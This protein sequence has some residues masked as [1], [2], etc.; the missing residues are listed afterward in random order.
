MGPYATIGAADVSFNR[1]GTLLYAAVV[2]V[3]ASDF[4]VLDQAA[5]EHPAA[6]P[7]VPGLLSFREAP[8]VLAAFE[9]LRVRPEVLLCDGQGIAHPRRFGLACHLGVWL[10]LPAVGCAKSRLC[11]EHGPL[12]VDRGACTPL[13][14]QGRTIGA[15]VRTRRGVKPLY[16]SA[17]HLCDLETAVQL[18]LATT[19]RF[20]L[21]VP[22]RLAHQLVNRLRS[23]SSHP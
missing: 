6:F 10:E 11:G 3:R 12:A 19:P 8:A 14:D 23:S 13:I 9:R 2:V 1:R 16:V 5:V 7:Y 15:V 17:G 4:A 18:V 20:R 21:P 22:A